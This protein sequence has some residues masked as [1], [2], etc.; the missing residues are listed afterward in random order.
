MSLPVEFEALARL[1]EE[2]ARSGNWALVA[3][4]ALAG[5]LWA[6]RRRRGRGGRPPP[7]GGT[8]GPPAAP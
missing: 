5:L 7:S 4:L 2:A 1:M 3:V 6:L 8:G